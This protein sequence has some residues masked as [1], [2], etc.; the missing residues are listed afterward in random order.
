MICSAA[1][2]DDFISLSSWMRY[3]RWSFPRLLPPWRTI[4]KQAFIVSK[5]WGVEIISSWLSLFWQIYEYTRD[6]IRFAIFSFE[7]DLW[8]YLR[9]LST[10]LLCFSLPC[11]PPIFL[12]LVQD[13][14]SS[15]KLCVVRILRISENTER[16]LKFVGIDTGLGVKRHK[17]FYLLFIY[18]HVAIKNFEI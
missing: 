16:A 13:P 11:T 12:S 14:F 15:I 4:N 6:C 9:C 3:A 2:N 1:V 17:V 10:P 8:V 5:Q 18:Y 7:F